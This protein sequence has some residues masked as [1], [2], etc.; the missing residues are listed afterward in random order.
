MNCAI[1]ALRARVTKKLE[2]VHQRLDEI[3]KVKYSRDVLHPEYIQVP[4]KLGDKETDKVKAAFVEQTG[5]KKGDNPGQFLARK[6][7]PELQRLDRL[8]KPDSR[9]YNFKGKKLSEY[10]INRLHGEQGRSPIEKQIQ[11]ELTAVNLSDKPEQ[12]I[13][14]LSK[15]GFAVLDPQD[16]DTEIVSKAFDAMEDYFKNTQ[17]ET[18]QEISIE[19]GEI[20]V[21]Y[22]TPKKEDPDAKGHRSFEHL[23]MQRPFLDKAKYDSVWDRAEASGLRPIL[24][25]FADMMETKSQAVLKQLDKLFKLPLGHAASFA[26][27]GQK[28]DQSTLR[29]IHCISNGELESPRQ[30]SF[31]NDKTKTKFHS[32]NA[33]KDDCIK[34]HTDWGLITLL[35]TASKRGLEFWYD[36][37]NNGKN[38]G[39]VRMETEPDQFLMMPGNVAEIVSGGKLKAVPHR[40][41][42]EG[43]RISLAYFTEVNKD[44]KLDDVKAALADAGAVDPKAISLFEEQVR[45]YLQTPETPLTGENFYLH[46]LHGGFNEN[47]PD[48]VA[49]AASKGLILHEKKEEDS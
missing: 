48:N 23:A 20:D 14:D 45:P 16:G 21:E 36:D 29:A 1:E 5:F 22:R 37:P 12:L 25:R 7:T 6:Q 39:W 32:N 43:D 35:P 9:V 31:V 28:T 4:D 19:D 26:K 33:P 41:I 15:Y 40:V 3:K 17:L 34:I 46:K 49:Y 18:K 24:K 11:K 47:S 27:V 30:D 8:M 42:S 44:T 2:N 13:D 38:S 10:E